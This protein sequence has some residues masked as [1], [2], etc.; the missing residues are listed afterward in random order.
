L[1]ISK[2]RKATKKVQEKKNTH[3]RFVNLTPQVLRRLNTFSTIQSV[4]I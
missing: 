1:N 2:T 4:P 3:K